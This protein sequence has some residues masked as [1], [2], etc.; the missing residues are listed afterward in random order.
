MKTKIGTSFGLALLLAMGVIA[1]MLALG[2]FSASKARAETNVQDIVLSKEGA[3]ANPQITITF[4]HEEQLTA[5]S[6]QIVVTFDKTWDIPS[7]IAKEYIALTTQQTTGGTSNPAIDPTVVA[8]ANSTV[9]TITIG[10]TDPS[11]T[12]VQNMEA[13]ATDVT[14]PHILVFSPLA[15]IANPNSQSTEAQAWITLVTSADTTSADGSVPTTGSLTG[16]SYTSWD[17]V[18]LRAVSLSPTS[19][20]NGASVTATGKGYTTGTL[21]AFLDLGDAN[22]YEP[23][24]DVDLGTST[25]ASGTAAVTFTANLPTFSAGANSINMRD[26]TGVIDASSATFTITGVVTTSKASV[27]R[28]ESVTVKLRQFTAGTVTAVTFGGAGADLAD[29]TTTTIPSSGTLDLDLTVP[30]TTSLG[31]QRV[32]VVSSNETTRNVNIEVAGAPVTL[33]PSTAVPDQKITISGTGFTT[34]GS[35]TVSA[36]SAT[37]T[38]AGITVSNTCATTT[39]SATDVDN[40][41]NFV[42]TYTVPDNSTTQ[43]AG[44]YQVVVT[45]SSSKTGQA[46]LTIPARSITLD[47][48]SSRRGSTVTFSGA[49]MAA[50]ASVGITYYVNSSSSPSVATVT[51]DSEGGYSGSF[52]VP[53]TANIPT[54]YTSNVTATATGSGGTAKTA[55]ATHHVPGATISVT[56]TTTSSGNNITV[57][58]DGFPGY[59]TMTGLSIGGVDSIS[60]P[61]PAT[62]SEGSFEEEFLV[63]QLSLGTQAVIATVGGVSANTSVVIEAAAAVEVVVEEPTETVFADEIT[64]DNLVRVWRFDNATKAWSFFD[65]TSAERIEAST[66]TDTTSGEVL[67]VNFEADTTFQGTAYTAGWNLIVLE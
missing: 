16:H 1:T 51:A 17:G 11:T 55:T 46:T 66:Y 13:Q 27:T 57:S 21:T 10:D 26:G 53:T 47:T 4:T 38:S 40:S 25:V 36:G 31:T 6:G 41:G 18:S 34:G 61:A 60:T 3:A 14:T 30:T 62:G 43:V 19:G 39:H 24:T 56:E 50:K 45:D 48:T 35:A 54:T 52:T 58:G 5:G 2:M 8:G 20:A 7:S 22:V 15:G 28:G 63:P 49:G 29:V 67:W 33:S 59:A 44:D 12:G 64:D 9:V 23:D 32:S 37:C 42:L 65:P